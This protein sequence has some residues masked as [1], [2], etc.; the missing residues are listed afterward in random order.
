MKKNI[1]I[2]LLVTTVVS[3][4]LRNNHYRVG[5]SPMMK[6]VFINILNLP[7]TAG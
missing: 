7:Q 1:L 4:F 2:F 3:A 6:T 5:I